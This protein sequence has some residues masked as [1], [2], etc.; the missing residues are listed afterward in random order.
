[1][2][3]LSFCRF[4]Y[5]LAHTST[6]LS[7]SLLLFSLF[8][9][10]LLRIFQTNKYPNEIGP[11]IFDIHSPRVP[12]TA[13]MVQR[14]KEMSA[15]LDPQLIW[16]NPDCGLKTRTWP[17]TEAQLKNMVEAAQQAREQFK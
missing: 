2:T 8:T 7:S 12:N 16:V 15:H 6:N 17:E 10:K 4:R 5:S 11:G 14:I 1:M 9:A 3:C 13:E